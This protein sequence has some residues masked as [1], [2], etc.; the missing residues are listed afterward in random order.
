MQC[1]TRLQKRKIHRPALGALLA[2][3]IV[4]TLICLAIALPQISFTQT[5]AQTAPTGFFTLTWE[6]NTE[7]DVAGYKVYRSTT[8]GTYGAP[9]AVIQGD[10]TTYQVPGNKFNQRPNVLFCGYGV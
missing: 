5:A 2:H 7:S 4:S 10:V 8:S 1:F 9:I 3:G 6:A